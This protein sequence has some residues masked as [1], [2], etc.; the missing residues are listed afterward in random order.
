MK[1]ARLFHVST[2]GLSPDMKRVHPEFGRID[3][4]EVSRHTLFEA[5]EMYR[6][7]E[8]DWRPASHIAI[9]SDTGRFVVRV[10][11]KELTLGVEGTPAAEGVPL[12]SEEIVARL[13]QPPIPV[14]VG[15]PPPP[16]ESLRRSAVAMVLF[17]AG[18]GLMVYALKPILVPERARPEEDLTFITG[19]AE[20]KGRHRA[21]AG[22]F[23]TG[24]QT[25]DRRLTISADGYV[26]FGEFG[27]RAAL[28]SGAHTFRIG[29]RENQTRLVTARNDI[30]EVV[31]ANTL[32]Y[33]GDTY[34]RV[35]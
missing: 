19:A 14:A 5:L 29:R 10:S 8:S 24:Q 18:V 16:P 23:T 12:A 31:D 27:P 30:I 22:A 13:S 9:Q 4:G 21:L 1:T 32:L 34:R 7:L 11:G 6:R 28:V 25:G 26:V 3:R 33:Y 15:P 2:F 35:K 17:L 20:L